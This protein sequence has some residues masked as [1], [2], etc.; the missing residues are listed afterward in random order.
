[1]GRFNQLTQQI[2]ELIQ[3][4]N[5]YTEEPDAFETQTEREMERELE[6]QI[7]KEYINKEKSEYFK[8]RNGGL[9]RVQKFLSSLRGVRDIYIS[10]GRVPYLKC[11]IPYWQFNK[12]SD[13]N[14]R[15]KNV[16]KTCGLKLDRYNASQGYI[17]TIF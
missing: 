14:A 4:N 16:L 13:W 8:K 1:M 12:F 9:K 7:D 2:K 3:N 11:Y 17:V 10:E 5:P 6:A 15:E